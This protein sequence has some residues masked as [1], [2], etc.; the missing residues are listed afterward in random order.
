MDVEKIFERFFSLLCY[1][2]NKNANF[3]KD[4][5]GR[6]VGTTIVCKHGNYH[7]YISP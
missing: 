3:S 5:G 2:T 1:G 7:I 4:R 6:P